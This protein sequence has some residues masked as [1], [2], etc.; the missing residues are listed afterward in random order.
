VDSAR[1]I[2]HN[3]RTGG[4]TMLQSLAR[5]EPQAYAL[6]RIVTGFLLLWHGMQKLFG[7]PGEMPAGAPPFVR[8]VGGP[9]ELI[10]GV[11][12]MIGLLTRPAA[13]L[14]SGLM[15]SAYWMVHAQR[16]L[17]PLQN[18]GE[19]AVAYCFVF[20]YIAA[21]GGGAWSIDASRATR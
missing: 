2:A 19:L 3:E 15:A 6:L 10:G 4:P 12:V 18:Q 7:F 9:I 1:A 20:L 5:Y 8:Y 16:A 14:C 11:L 13:F 17:L 21:R